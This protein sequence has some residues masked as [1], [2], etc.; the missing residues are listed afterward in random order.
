MD[1]E[2]LF[3]F[4]Q[5]IP[6]FHS[7][8][9]L[10]C[11][12]PPMKYLSSSLPLNLFFSSFVVEFS[13]PRKAAPRASFLRARTRTFGSVFARGK[14]PPQRSTRGVDGPIRIRLF[15][16]SRKGAGDVSINMRGARS[17][18]SITSELLLIQKLCQPVLH[19]HSR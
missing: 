12:L 17:Y 8:S 6:L 2:R 5:K 15:S 14:L 7:F 18:P 11:S 10:Y 1:V 3:F 9:F 16:R 4:M 19:C 13:F